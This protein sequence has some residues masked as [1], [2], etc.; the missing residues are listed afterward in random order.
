MEE[1]P[2]Y[3]IVGLIVVFSIIS[4]ILFSFWIHETH[5]GDSMVFCDI[6]FEQ[7]VSGL[8]IGS[9][10]KYQGLLV[11][12]VDSL[13]LDPQNP[14]KIHVRILIDEN[15]PLRESSVASLAI[16]GISGDTYIQ[17][18]AAKPNSPKLKP[19][20]GH[21]TIV[22]PSSPSILERLMDRAPQ[23]LDSMLETTNRMQLVFD[24]KNRDHLGQILQNIETFSTSLA[25]KTKDFEKIIDSTKHLI[26][27][28]ESSVL[29][30]E[31]VVKRTSKSVNKV[32][33]QMGDMLEENRLPIRN[34]TTNGLYEI[35]RLVA[36]FRKTLDSFELFMGDI[37][38]KLN[39][40][41][42]NDSKGEYRLNDI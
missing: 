12:S 3:I 31:D 19:P 6:Y 34:F 4:I 2:R 7:G 39:N 9:P 8:I 38:Q 28:V 22:I 10:V 37:S 42:P 41:I 1:N 32:T 11:G 26:P 36:E 25:N 23:V 18:S 30:M 35:S 14:D 40:L 20:P 24:Q 13:E 21:E 17:I 29:T 33:D 16:T 15:V 5:R 27:I